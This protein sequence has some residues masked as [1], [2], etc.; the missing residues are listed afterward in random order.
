MERFKKLFPESKRWIGLMIGIASLC[1]AGAMIPRNI[2][3]SPTDSV[4]AHIFF[5]KKHFKKADLK[6]DAL[7]VLPFYTHIRPNCWPCMVVKY[8]KCQ[9][10]EKLEERQK[11]NFYCNNVFLGTAMTHSSK[12]VPVKPFRFNGIIPE[13]KFFAM[14]VSQNSY[15]S[16][17][18]GLENIKDV[19]DIAIPMF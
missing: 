16:R 13:G 12:G 14:G 9:A 3:I 5:L 11:L 6:K 4:G 1:Y 2:S 7:V 8:I 19:K 15:D 17:Y 18:V 10:G